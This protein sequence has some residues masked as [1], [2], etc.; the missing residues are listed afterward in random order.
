MLVKVKDGNPVRL[1]HEGV[2][3]FFNKNQVKD[4]PE[5]ILLGFRGVLVSAEEEPNKIRIVKVDEA[6]NNL[7]SKKIIIPTKKNKK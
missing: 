3:Y 5:S 2:R 6:I 4:C 1:V 7:N